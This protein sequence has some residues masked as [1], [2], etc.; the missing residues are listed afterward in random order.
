LNIKVKILIIQQFPSQAD[1]ARTVGIAE[2][3]LSR[4]VREKRLPTAEQRR[5]IAAALKASENEIFAQN[6]NRETAGNGGHAK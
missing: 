2:A 4:I 6:V 5:K 1:F 3:T